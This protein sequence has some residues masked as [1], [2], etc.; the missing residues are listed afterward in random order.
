MVRHKL[1]Q[2][3]SGNWHRRGQHAG[4]VFQVERVSFQG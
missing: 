3:N 2:M 1:R 4:D